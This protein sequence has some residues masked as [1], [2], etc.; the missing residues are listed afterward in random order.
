MQMLM[1]LVLSALVFGTLAQLQPGG[2]PQMPSGMTSVN[3]C[4]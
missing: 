1:L 2:V 3:T 4:R